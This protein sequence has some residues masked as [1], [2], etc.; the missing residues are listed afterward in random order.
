MQTPD[1]VFDGKCRH[2]TLLLTALK[3]DSV[4]SLAGE[5]SAWVGH[6]QEGTENVVAVR[7]TAHVTYR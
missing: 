6:A 7:L 2:P 1:F 5:A 4:P 3:G